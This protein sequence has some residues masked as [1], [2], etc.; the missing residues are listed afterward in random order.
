MNQMSFADAEY[1]DKLKQARRE[2]CLIEMDQ[3]VPWNGLIT[4]IEPHYPKGDGGRPA[5]P[6]LAMLH[7]L[8]DAEL[9]RL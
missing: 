3:V 9:V 4:L 8:S 6:F 7:G 2:R 5:Y 1:T